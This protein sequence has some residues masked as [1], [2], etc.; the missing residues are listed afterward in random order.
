M[1]LWKSICSFEKNTANIY[2]IVCNTIAIKEIYF[3]D[4][5]CQK[6]QEKKYFNYFFSGTIPL[7]HA[8]LDFQKHFIELQ[9]KASCKS[10][11]EKITK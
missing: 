4:Y 9:G 10:Q 1:V 3:Q 8:F 11:Q 5:F 7:I 2:L 6:P